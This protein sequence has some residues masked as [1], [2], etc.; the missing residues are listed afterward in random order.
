[1]NLSKLPE[2]QTE[3]ELR[4]NVRTLQDRLEDSQEQLK[5]ANRDSFRKGVLLSQIRTVVRFVN[6]GLPP[7]DALE[8][9]R[10]RIE[11]AEGDVMATVI[12]A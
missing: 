9:I 3:E 12:K 5:H 4:E 8:E 10:D 6:A 7:E 11:D 2:N 1:M